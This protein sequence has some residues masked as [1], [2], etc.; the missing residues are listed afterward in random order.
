MEEFLRDDQGNLTG[1]TAVNLSW[2]G[3]KMTKL[4]TY[5]VDVDMVLIAAGFLG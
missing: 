2:A 1:V 5:P 4:D 3:G